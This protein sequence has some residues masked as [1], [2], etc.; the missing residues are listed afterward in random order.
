MAKTTYIITGP[1]AS[2]KSDFAHE[3]ALRANG[4]IIN[5]DSVQIYRGLETLSASP[6]KN[7]PSIDNIPYKLYSIIRPPEK[8]S[9]G[10]YAELAHAEAAQADTPI[11]VG[12]TGF[13][14]SALTDGF[15]DLPDVSRQSQLIAEGFANKHAELQKCDPVLAAKLHPNDTQRLTRALSIFIETGQ[16]LSSFQQF[17]A[18]G[19]GVSGSA[20]RG[21]SLIKIAILPPRAELLKRAAARR[22]TMLANGA[23]DEVKMNISFDIKAIGFREIRS[24]LRDE[25]SRDEML[26]LWSIADAQYIKRQFT[27]L[28]NKFLAQKSPSLA[29]GWTAKQDGVVVNNNSNQIIID[30]I[31]TSKDIEDVLRK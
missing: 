9:A 10:R 22:E 1:T 2:G 18:K 13:Y 14:L 16:P 30:H 11:F 29:K 6:L 27:W 4:T 20:G 7:S 8:M 28:R 15:S 21:G 26:R 5:A 19:G 23:L 3:L 25:I 17:P 12:G 24:Y 31:P